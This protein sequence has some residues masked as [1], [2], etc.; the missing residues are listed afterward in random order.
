M[1]YDCNYE[2]TEESEPVTNNENGSNI[3]NYPQKTKH[4]HA[5]LREFSNQ[6]KRIRS[7]DDFKE[8]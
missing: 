8:K 1:G 7:W 4:L 3:S 6:P 5:A 2:F